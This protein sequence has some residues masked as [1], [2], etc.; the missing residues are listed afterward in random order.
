[1]FTTSALVACVS[2]EE[3]CAI[4]V[5]TTAQ[6]NPTMASQPLTGHE[7]NKSHQCVLCSNI[8]APVLACDLAEQITKCKAFHMGYPVNSEHI[9]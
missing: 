5:S 4:L 2:C 3:S 6:A 8:I 7:C 9:R 1:M